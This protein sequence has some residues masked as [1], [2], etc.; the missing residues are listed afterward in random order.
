[1]NVLFYTFT[2][3]P[4][5]T[6]IPGETVAP[7]VAEC[8]LKEP[9]TVITPRISL[10]HENP[11]SYNYVHIPTW[12][13]YYNVED[14]TW[15]AGIWYAALQCD[16]LASYRNDIA[17][18]TQYVLRATTEYDG[19]IVDAA[20]PAKASPTIDI[21]SPSRY[22]NAYSID[23]MFTSN[24][25]EGCYI[26]GIINKEPQ[27]VGAVCYY[28]FTPAN[29]REFCNAMFTNLN[30]ANVGIT[31]ITTE[32]AKMLF[33]PFQYITSCFWLPMKIPVGISVTNVSLG[34]W[35]LT[36]INAVLLVNMIDGVRAFFSVP[37]HPQASA[38]GSFL[39]TP[40]HCSR[41]IDFPALGTISL[42]SAQMAGTLE[43]SMNFYIDLTSGIANVLVV[44]SANNNTL[45]SG[46]FMLGIPVAIA[47]ERV[48]VGGAIKTAAGIIQNDYDN[49]L[50][51][52]GDLASGISNASPRVTSTN[53]GGNMAAYTIDPVLKSVFAIVVDEN[54]AEKGRPLCAMRVLSTLFGGYIRCENAHIALNCTANECA[55]VESFLNGGFYLE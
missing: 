14:W 25:N 7:Y 31:E 40:P 36:G 55:R 19:G 3:A 30:W 1:M 39:N 13:R 29:F 44:D 48:D 23:G 41:I 5:S 21:R 8:V 10:R 52:A 24:A 15:S 42:D 37:S 43:I 11:T 38:R 53:G 6:A 28:A 34:Y 12:G 51:L 50:P 18:S 27:S 9:C 46:Q 47:Q 4:N 16:V 45:Y 17:Q 54:V 20:Y 33:N 2:K 49:V 22:V 26:V 35:T 32:L